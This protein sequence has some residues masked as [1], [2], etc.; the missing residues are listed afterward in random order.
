MGTFSKLGNAVGGAGVEEKTMEFGPLENRFLRYS[1]E[2]LAQAVGS[3][4]LALSR[5]V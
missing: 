3:W 4:C 5:E 2:G 1:Q